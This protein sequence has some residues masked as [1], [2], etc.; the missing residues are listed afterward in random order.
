MASITW[1]DVT[2]FASEMSAVDSDAQTDILAYVNAEVDTT[3]F[4]GGESSPKLKLARRADPLVP[5][6]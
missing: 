4:A 3:L 6:G 2:N 5:G 1:A